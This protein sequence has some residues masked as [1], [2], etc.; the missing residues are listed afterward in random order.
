M[1]SEEERKGEVRLWCSI[2]V[3][4]LNHAFKI[5][6]NMHGLTLQVAFGSKKRK[7]IFCCQC[8]TDQRIKCQNP[9]NN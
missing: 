9:Q 4:I 5:E 1:Q 7:K 3:R 8:K 6:E 2:F